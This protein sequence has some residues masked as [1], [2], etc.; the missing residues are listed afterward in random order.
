MLLLLSGISAAC[1]FF[2]VCT[3]SLAAAITG[4][5][6][7]A[8]LNFIHFFYGIGA[9]AGPQLVFWLK[10]PVTV[11]GSPEHWREVFFYLA[12]PIA[13]F[14][15]I[16]MATT[17]PKTPTEDDK[18]ALGV[19]RSVL[20]DRLCWLMALAMGLMMGM[21]L[22]TKDWLPFYLRDCYKL[23]PEHYLSAF[24]VFFSISRLAG[25]WLLEKAG[26]ARGLLLLLIVTLVIYLASFILGRAGVYLLPLTGF[27]IALMFPTVVAVA[28][29]EY[30]T[31]TAAVIAFVVTG[32]GLL[33]GVI[34]WLTGLLN[35]TLGSEWGYRF[36][37]VYVLIAML[38]VAG[39]RR[40]STYDKTDAVSVPDAAP[41][42]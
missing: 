31:R 27:T 30:P 33:T 11:P 24:Y 2:E 19:M 28:V 9:I 14:I 40:L 15:A 21:E 41:E 6:A 37:I 23:A 10:P 17:F 34:S 35:H 32:G 26:Y 13:V 20:S 4:P 22:G 25:G 12:L 42:F 3:N 39:I 18:S 16:T 1:G 29:R 38:T 36:F 8:S 5:K 7:A